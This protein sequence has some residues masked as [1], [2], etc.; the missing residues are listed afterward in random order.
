RPAEEACDRTERR[1]VLHT[2]SN[3][4]EG[5]PG[6][7]KVEAAGMGTGVV[8]PGTRSDHYR[9]A[10]VVERPPVRD[11]RQTRLQRNARQAATAEQVHLEEAGASGSIEIVAG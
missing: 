7:L 6:D 11:Q 1:H 9:V 4:E 5:H 10:A 3:A 8:P 2:V